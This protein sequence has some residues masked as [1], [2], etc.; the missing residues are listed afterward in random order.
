MS[1]AVLE[2]MASGLPVIVSENTGYTG[3]VSDG[4]EGFV[5]SIRSPEQ[6]AGRIAQLLDADDLRQAMG[7][8]AR[9]RAEQYTW[10]SYGRRLE[11]TYLPIIMG[12][13]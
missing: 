5:V 10:S 8:N 2:A 6:I 9:H 4:R 3:I 7:A 13:S 1:L 12:R 11:E